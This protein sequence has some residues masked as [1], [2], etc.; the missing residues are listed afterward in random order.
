LYLHPANKFVAHFMGE[1]NALDGEVREVG[2]ERLRVETAIGEVTAARFVPP[3]VSVGQ[4]VTISLRPEVIQLGDAPAGMPN[5]YRGVLHDTIYLG[6]SAQHLVNV[7]ANGHR[8]HEPLKVLELN[9]RYVARDDATESV[10]LWF[11]PED[12]VV[13]TH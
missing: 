1:T 10:R 8:A 6:E 13:L 2:A 7:G 12:V 9:P 4:I 3:G 11:K 5:Q